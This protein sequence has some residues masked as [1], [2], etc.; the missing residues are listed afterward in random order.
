MNP[1]YEELRN[2]YT[3]YFTMR[4]MGADINNKFGLLSLVG[5]LTDKARQKNPDASCYQVLIK[6]TD[7]KSVV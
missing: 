3:K 5:F 2:I 6:I 1:S 4:N 7:R